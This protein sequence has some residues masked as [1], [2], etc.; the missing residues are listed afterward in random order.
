MYNLHKKFTYATRENLA[1]QID[2][3]NLGMSIT[4]SD[5]AESELE[6]EIDSEKEI[7]LDEILDAKFVER[8]NKLNIQLY[9][10][11]NNKCKIDIRLSVPRKTNLKINSENAGFN[12]SDIIGDVITSFENGKLSL[13]QISGSM[14]CKTENGGIK[15][16][17]S[18]GPM[19]LGTENGEVS[20]KRSNGKIIIQGENGGVKCSRCVGTLEAQTENGSVKVIESGFESANIQ[21]ENGGIYFEF[22]KTDKGKF[23]FKNENGKIHLVIPEEIPYSIIAKNQLGNFHIGMD[24]DYARSKDGSTQILEMIKESGNV[25]IFAENENGRISLVNTQG[26]KNF[27]HHQI[28]LG[29]IA[30]GL[31]HVVDKI[32]DQE[33]R[34]K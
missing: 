14:D 28:N 34:K 22:H 9:N 30:K 1:L 32:P 5:K 23:S 12:I 6:I 18:E 27:K 29:G 8:K 15:I 26:K 33:K 2:T 31:D 16:K 20:L 10:P 25:K 24:G 11:E 7:A 4:G 19:K 13:D 17:D 3:E 21:N